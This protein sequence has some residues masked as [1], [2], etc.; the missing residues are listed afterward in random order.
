MED[1]VIISLYFHRF[2]EEDE[3]RALMERYLRRRAQ[4]GIA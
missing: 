4:G 2:V 3:N 1:I